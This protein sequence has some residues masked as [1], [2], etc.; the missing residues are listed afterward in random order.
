[1]SQA[2]AN[3]IAIKGD[4][5]VRHVNYLNS[6]DADFRDFA[7]IF[8]NGQVNLGLDN[9]LNANAS[10]SE[11]GV[12]DAP[13]LIFMKA[14]LETDVLPENNRTL[15]AVYHFASFM[16]TASLGRRSFLMRENLNIS[17]TILDLAG[18]DRHLLGTSPRT[19]FLSI[20]KNY[21]DFTHSRK[22]SG[23]ASTV[24]HAPFSLNDDELLEFCKN[25]A[26]TLF[27]SSLHR[28]IKNAE[29]A[30]FDF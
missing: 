18:K 11:G 20:C 25:E 23:G 22:L 13:F 4:V 1:M 27:R 6:S 19:G 24:V 17:G 28:Y 8:F 3:K 26:N 21:R 15:A 2:I 16:G 30:F 29:T 14:K 9:Y 12:P 7:T 10:G 5:E